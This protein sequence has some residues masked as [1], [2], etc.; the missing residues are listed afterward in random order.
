MTIERLHPHLLPAVV[1]CCLFA[2]CLD[3]ETTTTVNTDG[4]CERRIVVA[5]LQSPF[6]LHWDRTWDTTRAV[7]GTESDSVKIVLTKK[8]NSFDELA[9]EYRDSGDKAHFGVRVNVERKFR[10]FFSYY[11]YHESYGK[12]SRDT[13]VAPETFLTSDEMTRYTYG[14]TSKA[15]ADKVEAWHNRNL[16]EIVFGT[17]RAAAAALPDSSTIL[18]AMD[19]HKDAFYHSLFENVNGIPEIVGKD[20]KIIEA[21]LDS[22]VQLAGRVMMI[23][24]SPALRTAFG[25]GVRAAFQHSFS[26]DSKVGWTFTNIVSLPGTIVQTNAGQVK[27]GEAIWKLDTDRLSFIDYEMHAESRVLNMWAIVATGLVLLGLV[28]A[29]VRARRIPAATQG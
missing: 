8:F 1:L 24:I 12:F 17:A 11:D 23:R 18:A 19:S 26:P 20:G 4:T 28:A 2:G 10:W 6:P 22:L 14:D 25:E 13:L 7:V 27:R 9:N 16:F 21:G 3:Q 5:S 29:L 15:L